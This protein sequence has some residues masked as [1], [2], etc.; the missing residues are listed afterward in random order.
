VPLHLH[1]AILLACS[2]SC[3]CARRADVALSGCP[4]MNETEV[5]TV[6]ERVL[7]ARRI[8]GHRDIQPDRRDARAIA[9]ARRRVFAIVKLCLD[10]RGV[11]ACI[12]FYQR[13]GYEDWDSRLV[14]GVRTWRY[15]PY[16]LNGRPQPVC[17]K[18]TFLYYPAR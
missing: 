2:L 15:S 9:R 17:A 14:D 4:K 5:R 8:S 1:H 11:P 13:S 6:P 7:E 3:A 16:L 18:I 10:D 12:E